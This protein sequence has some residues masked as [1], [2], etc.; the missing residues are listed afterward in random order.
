MEVYGAGYSDD[1]DYF[2]YNK[3]N[4][5]TH[6]EA[7]IKQLEKVV[8][9][10]DLV[11]SSLQSQKGSVLDQMPTYKNH[12]LCF[13]SFQCSIFRKLLAVQQAKEESK[14]NDYMVKP[15]GHLVLVTCGHRG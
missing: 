15:E 8:E 10:Y 2:K 13:L 4:T 3:R 7:M 11:I 1:V 12:F 14:D 5:E 6:T 9:C